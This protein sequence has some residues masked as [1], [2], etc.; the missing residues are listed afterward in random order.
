MSKF[1]SIHS[2]VRSFLAS[3]SYRRNPHNQ[4]A[5]DI[6][7]DS[8]L[9]HVVRSSSL[10]KKSGNSKYF[11]LSGFTYTLL[12]LLAASNVRNSRK[13]AD[14][15]T[16]L[17]YAT[18]A[19]KFIGYLFLQP[20]ITLSHALW[21]IVDGNSLGSLVG[22]DG[23]ILEVSKHNKRPANRWPRPWSHVHKVL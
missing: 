11:S 9:K 19:V 16:I 10:S 22:C 3:S 15:A 2:L 8:T 23:Q 12:R 4:P 21:I 1:I 18:S 20:R 5:R 17:H 6:P 13:A 14:L 7:S